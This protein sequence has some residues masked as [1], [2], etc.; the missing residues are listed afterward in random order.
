[1]ISSWLDVSHLIGASTSCARWAIV[2]SSSLL[3]T[4]YGIENANCKELLEIVDKI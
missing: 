4:G 3:A 2:N 1:V